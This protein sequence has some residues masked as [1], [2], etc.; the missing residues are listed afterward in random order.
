MIQEHSKHTYVIRLN[1]DENC[2][3]PSIT[4]PRI[5]KKYWYTNILNIQTFD[6][7]VEKNLFTVERSCT[8]PQLLWNGALATVSVDCFAGKCLQTILPTKCQVGRRT[9]FLSADEGA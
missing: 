4:C 8:T 6:V 3:G 5:H 1:Q 7:K 2:L 9:N